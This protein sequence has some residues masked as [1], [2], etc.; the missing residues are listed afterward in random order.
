MRSESAH[1]PERLPYGEGIYRRRILLAAAEGRVFADLEDDFHRYGI[2]IEHDGDRV[3][4]VR[5]GAGRFPWSE[6]AN[7]LTPLLAFRG[8]PLAT[9]L[10]AVSRRADARQSCTHA[11]D[12]AVLAIAHAAAG[13]ARRQYDVAVPDREEG[14][15]RARLER[16]GELVLAW[17]LW[18]SEIREPPPYA[19]RELRG[20]G[21]GRWAESELD[22]DAAEAAIV[23][24]RGVFI[25]NGRL[26]DFD[27]ARDASVLLPWAESSC[28]SFTPGIAEKALR[29]RGSIREFTH[30][31]ERLLADVLRPQE[32]DAGL[33]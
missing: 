30:H 19:G 33:G 8:T 15:T 25:A 13:R 7:F 20:P 16:D 18:G 3:T 12:L 23:L 10:R 5:G 6:C 26:G 9:S 27:S 22:P 2:E 11:F 24:R 21:L 14:V 32:P 17:D 29:V 4:A 28:R 31:P 1:H